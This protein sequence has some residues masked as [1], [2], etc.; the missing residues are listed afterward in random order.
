MPWHS[1]EYCEE[2]EE[3]PDKSAK[4]ILASSPLALAEEA[5]KLCSQTGFKPVEIFRKYLWYLLRERKF[6]QEAADD[7]V[8]LKSVLNLSDDQVCRL[9]PSPMC[10]GGGFL[11]VQVRCGAQAWDG[12]EGT[13]RCKRRWRIQAAEQ[14]LLVA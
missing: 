3:T 6:D 8:Y 1:I 13:L 10:L 12:K 11:T 5:R 2:C 7:L 9:F 4:R 14:I